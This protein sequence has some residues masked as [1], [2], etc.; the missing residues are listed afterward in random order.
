MKLF[1]ICIGKTN[2]KGSQ[3]IF[4]DS[5]GKFVFQICELC[6][7]QYEMQLFVQKNKEMVQ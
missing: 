7:R 1:K 3:E 4:R 6:T 2:L 5:R